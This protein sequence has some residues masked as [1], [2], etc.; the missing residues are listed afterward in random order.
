MDQTARMKNAET[1]GNKQTDR[2]FLRT[3]AKK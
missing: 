1:T 3:L 2:P